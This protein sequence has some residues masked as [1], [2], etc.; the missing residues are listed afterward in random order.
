MSRLKGKPFEIVAISLD[1]TREILVHMLQN[2]KMPGIQTWD[3]AGRENPVGKLYNALILPTWYLLDENGVIRARDPFG[4]KLIP[5][6]EAVLAGSAT[7]KAKHDT[8]ADE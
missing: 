4:R 3:K 1:D 5:A 6:V 8:T 2:I 7:P